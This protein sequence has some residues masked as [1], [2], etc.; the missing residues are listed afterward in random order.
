MFTLVNRGRILFTLF[1][2]SAFMLCTS[3]NSCGS[4]NYA[5]SHHTGSVKKGKKHHK[6]PVMLFRYRTTY[7]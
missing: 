7:R 1:L 2:V 5:H 3:L 6:K 4:A